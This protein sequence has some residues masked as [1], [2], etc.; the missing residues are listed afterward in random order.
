MDIFV[1]FK[2]ISIH[3]NRIADLVLE[4]KDDGM[5]VNANLELKGSIEIKNLAFS[6]SN[7]EDTIFQN[8]NLK[9]QQ[10]EVVSIIGKSGC[11]KSTFLKVILG[12]YKSNY[13]EILYDSIPIVTI[14][15]SVLRKKVGTVLQS[16]CLF[17]GSVADNVSFFS[18]EFDEE[19][20]YSC[21]EMACIKEDIVRLPMGLNSDVGNT[22]SAGQVQRL[23]LARAFYKNPK[24]L[25]MDEA[26]SNLNSE[27]E[28]RILENIRRLNVTAIIVS[29]RESIV[30]FSDKVFDFEKQCLVEKAMENKK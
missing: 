15:S 12:L 17:K 2:L 23:M 6:Y 30:K 9:I 8:L 5:S 7:Y 26:T 4:E 25:I 1:Q 21:L 19:R 22:F 10:G 13:G 29:H 16:D 18:E 20:I 3:T 28:N 24:I 14:G 11:G 27:I